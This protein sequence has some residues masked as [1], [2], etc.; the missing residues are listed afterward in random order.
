MSIDDV[1]PPA[2]LQPPV[3][4]DVSK[5]DPVAT[6]NCYPVAGPA[7]RLGD[8]G[9]ALLVLLTITNLTSL[10]VSLIAQATPFD[11][12]DG[13]VPWSVIVAVLFTGYPLPFWW[14]FSATPGKMLAGTRIVDRH[15]RRMGLSRAVIRSA[16]LFVGF[17]WILA[18][19][20]R[21]RG[22]HD[23]IAGTFVISERAGQIQQ[24]PAT[25][26]V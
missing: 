12:R 13:L 5:P 10:A 7:H 23:M 24:A 17:I 19:Y 21:Y 25:G 1:P 9:L 2:T 26:A 6:I 8:Y 22:I 20:P 16:F 14:R 4:F 11:I 3:A 18:D 15:G